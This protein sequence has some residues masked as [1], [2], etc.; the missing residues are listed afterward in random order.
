SRKPQ[1]AL[2]DQWG[3]KS[4]KPTGGGCLVTEQIF[5]SRLK[6]FLSWPYRDAKETAVL[7]WGRY[8][9]LDEQTV[10]V[11]GR[12]DRENELLIAHGHGGDYCLRLVDFPGP[13]LLLKTVSLREEMLAVAGGIVQYFSK[14]RNLPPQQIHYWPAGEAQQT[15]TVTARLLSEDEIKRMGR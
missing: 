11:L 14:A 7:K 13:L 1:M 9:R 2:A 15:K 6:D 3:L 4:Y 5:G 12:D 10:G 8:F